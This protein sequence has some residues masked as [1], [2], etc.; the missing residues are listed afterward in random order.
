MRAQESAE[1]H[2]RLASLMAVQR[3]RFASSDRPII[4]VPPQPDAGPVAEAEWRQRKREV[5]PW[6]RSAREKL[7][8]AVREHAKK[9]VEQAHQYACREA[10]VAQTEANRWWE[11]LKAGDC[12]TV[13][14][15]LE[16]AFADNPAPVAVAQAQGNRALLVL[17]VPALDVLPGKKAHVTPTGRLSSRPWA[18]TELN[19]VYVALIGAH[20]LA[21]LREAFAVGPSLESVRIIGVRS[22]PDDASGVLF[23][24][25]TGRTEAGGSDDAGVALLAAAHRG[26][27]RTGRTGEVQA[28]PLAD[29]DPSARV[30]ASNRFR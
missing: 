18:K 11:A 3:E 2:D 6:R 21:T 15:A 16:A 27:R 23:D 17:L 24:V 14:A 4:A 30:A 13:T 9:Q 10:E 26:L 28:W 1:V 20:L 25:T 12:P 19:E 22:G 5:R 7:H 8:A 29:L